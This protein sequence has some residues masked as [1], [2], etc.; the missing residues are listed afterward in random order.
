MPPKNQQNRET[1]KI[2]KIGKGSVKHR[3][4]YVVRDDPTYCAATR[5]LV[6]TTLQVFI[7][8]QTELW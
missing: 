5:V 7:T 3:W 4:F 2:M 8:F 1:Q 6:F